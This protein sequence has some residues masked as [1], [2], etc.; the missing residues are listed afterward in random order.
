MPDLPSGTVTLLFTDIAGSTRLLQQ[1]G[2]RYAAVLAAHQ[3]LLR[4]A[5]QTCNGYEVGAEGDS[6]FVTFARAPD[7]VA[8]AVAA[9]QALAAHPWPAGTAVRVRIGLHTGAP[10]TVGEQYVGLDVHHA[11]RIGAAGHGGQ[12]LLSQATHGLVRHELPEG[13]SLRD[14]G[15][16]RLKDLV[17]AEHI[18]QLVIP[19][20]PADFPPLTTLDSR[21]HNLPAQPTPLIGRAREIGAVTEL[22]CRADVRLVTLTGPG[23]TGKTRLA[24]QVA[25]EVLDTFADGVWFV[26]LAP[27]SDPGL[28]ASTIAQA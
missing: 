11:A 1:L 3:Q 7:A 2:D 28:V 21:R 18:F 20:L 19:N 24:L 4:R 6:F 23:G 13:V 17:H 5:F 27:I 9:Q 16:H 15:E 12:V 10:A 8:A 25:A 14:L 22:L 26:N